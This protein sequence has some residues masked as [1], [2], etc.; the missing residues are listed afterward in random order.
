VLD[1]ERDRWFPRKAVQVPQSIRIF[2]TNGF[3]PL[4]GGMDVRDV[5]VI[6]MPMNGPMQGATFLRHLV[7]FLEDLSLHSAAAGDRSKL[8][9]NLYLSRNEA[10]KAHV[11]VARE[12]K[13][14]YEKGG[15]TC[16]DGG[17]APFV[18]RMVEDAE[19]KA[20]FR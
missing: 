18:S 14:W 17:L 2:I 7:N 6:G 4:A 11:A 3:V 15:S 1:E 9:L 12:L 10:V 13:T 20:S 19:G 16:V 8:E 5:H